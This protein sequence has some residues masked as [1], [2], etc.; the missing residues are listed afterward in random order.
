M[1]S[2]VLYMSLKIITYFNAFQHLFFPHNCKSCGADYIAISSFLCSR[3]IAKLP[4]THF[5][6]I[7]NN[8]VEKI[9]AGRIHLFAG[10]AL[11]YFTKASLLQYILVQLKYNN[12]QAAGI[13][14]GNQL[15]IALKKS[16]RFQQVDCIIPLPLHPK[17][18][19]MRGYNQAAVIATGIT[20]TFNKPILNDA[21]IRRVFTK[22][23]TQE[24]RTSRWQN[25]SGVFEVTRPELLKNKH[26][27]LIDDVVTTGA[28]LESC[29][30]AILAVSGTQLSIATI[31]YTL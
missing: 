19:Y 24:N 28:S 8:P 6:E 15:G 3:C 20:A 10:S 18:E 13:F 7:P 2:L 4:L 30:L 5:T 25:M 14:L 12:N 9:F 22:T 1:G 17:K 23:Q 11:Y 26:I 31:A 29:G 21:V 27:L 16:A